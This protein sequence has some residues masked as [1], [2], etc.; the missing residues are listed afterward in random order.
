MKTPLKAFTLGSNIFSSVSLNT[1]TSEIWPRAY[2]ENVKGVT[3]KTPAAFWKIRM[4]CN[5]TQLQFLARYM[6]TFHLITKGRV[7]GLLQPPKSTLNHGLAII[8][9]ICR[10]RGHR[11]GPLKLNRASIAFQPEPI[12]YS[13]ELNSNLVLAFECLLGGFHQ[14]LNFVLDMP[15]DL[16]AR[17]RIEL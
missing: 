17:Q 4:I 5:T 11:R 13:I 1:D 2:R 6:N 7:A 14:A 3:S 8:A 15:F 12:S 16:G 10:K 9:S